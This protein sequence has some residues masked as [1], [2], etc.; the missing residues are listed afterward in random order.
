MINLKAKQVRK[1]SLEIGEPV[2]IDIIRIS[3]KMTKINDQVVKA[4][5]IGVTWADVDDPKLLADALEAIMD[6]IVSSDN[7]KIALLL[8]LKRMKHKTESKINELKSMVN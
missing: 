1:I 6:F 4:E 5:G 8:A 3:T 2:D 7:R